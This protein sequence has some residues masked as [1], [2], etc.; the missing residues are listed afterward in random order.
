MISKKVIVLLLSSLVFA[1]GSSDEQI[2]SVVEEE[3]VVVEEETVVVEEETVVV[4]EETVV[5]EEET[6][7]VEE[8]T[9]TTSSS[10]TTTTTIPVYQ[11]G[12]IIDVL[13]IQAYDKD[14]IAEIPSE[15]FKREVTINGVRI[16]ATGNV[17]G[18]SAVPDAFIEKVARMVELFTDPNGEDID[19]RNK[20]L[21]SKH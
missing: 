16:M 13:T 6:V 14:R 4:E 2:S 9:T 3:T 11:K 19:A 17:G 5:V 7:V 8:E 18:Q 20:R 1:C 10:T 15:F 12:E 21:L